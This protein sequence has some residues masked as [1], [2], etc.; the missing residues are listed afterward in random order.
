MSAG[1]P[2][3]AREEVLVVQLV[4]PYQATAISLGWQQELDLGQLPDAK[5]CV[6]N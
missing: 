5:N 1:S 4:Q 3:M 6:N 2:A